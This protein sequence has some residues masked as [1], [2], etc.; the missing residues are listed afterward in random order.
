M[1]SVKSFETEVFSLEVLVVDDDSLLH[2]PNHVEHGTEA[3]L[4]QGIGGDDNIMDRTNSMSH[5]F[6]LKICSMRGNASINAKV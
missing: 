3:G 2:I 4:L 6:S 5:I 1:L